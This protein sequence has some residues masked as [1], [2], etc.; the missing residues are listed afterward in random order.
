MA[1]DDLTAEQQDLFD[2]FKA[3][4]GIDNDEN[5][6]KVA[7]LLIVNEF[8]LNNAISHYFDTGFESIEQHPP[9]IGSAS[10]TNASDSNI[11]NSFA[12]GIDAHDE[13]QSELHNRREHGFHN[14]Q[15]NIMNL[16]QQLFVDNFIPRL[17]KAPRISNNWQLEV[18]IHTSLIEKREEERKLQEQELESINSNST[19]VSRSNGE[20][21]K[22]LYKD[23]VKKRNTS[24][25]SSNSPLGALW[26]ILLIVPKTLLQLILSAL[27]HLFGFGS[28]EVFKGIGDPNRLR[29]SFKYANFNPNFNFASWLA[30][31]LLRQHQR[32]EIE[33]EPATDSRSEYQETL[34]ESSREVS[35]K[36][37]ST[38]DANELLSKFNIETSNFNE[39][40]EAAQKQYIWLFVILINNSEEAKQYLIETLKSPGFNKLFNKTSG[41]F[42]E[43]SIYIN[44]VEENPESF[45]VAQTY[46]VKR[47]PYVML[48]GNVST[49]P[50]VLSS[51][52]ILYKSNLASAF[53]G[54]ESELLSTSGKIVKNVGKLLEKFNPQLISARFDQQEI[55]FARLI[56][57]QQDDAYIQSL[58]LDKEK[59]FQKE[60]EQKSRLEAEN[61]SK[62]HKYFLL[63]LVGQ[64]YKEEIT[65]GSEKSR[66]AI[67]LPDGKRIVE[68]FNKSVSVSE[69]Y[70]FIEL[71]LFLDKLVKETEIGSEEGI[72]E[73][74]EQLIEEVNLPEELASTP[75]TRDLYFEKFPFKF[76]VIQP[77]PKKIISPSD[78]SIG[79]LAEF[80][81]GA[82][83]LVEYLEDSDDESE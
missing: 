49:S 7:Q 13:Q 42:K 46:K 48:V 31:E 27:K 75:L 71:K 81:S 60:Q 9:A 17:P 2:Q 37:S 20:N 36:D 66:M 12:S 40:H 67:K 32:Q 70:L 56:K 51:M 74:L 4:S 21:E 35:D 25:S 29:K 18:G 65:N 73:S 52:S 83:L 8:N 69:I 44:N 80:K 15:D 24:S 30:E 55:Q 76:E 28:T 22:E 45:E 43:T 47:L 10:S 63:N 79:D 72:K 19:R 23:E 5:D 26:I 16:Q 82:N 14:A 78:A 50:Q 58:A 64:N 34:V 62:L 41:L 68:S 54:S 39:C 3:I 33:D 38:P 6:E 1:R 77:F 59:K 11:A 61:T 57:Q 53:L